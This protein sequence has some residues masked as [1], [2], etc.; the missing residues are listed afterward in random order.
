MALTGKWGEGCLLATQFSRIALSR[1]LVFQGQVGLTKG[2]QGV[3]GLG[4][5]QMLQQ[6]TADC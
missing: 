3:W 4:D 1:V 2:A 5:E 6:T